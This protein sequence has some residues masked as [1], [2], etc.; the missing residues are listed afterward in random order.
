MRWPQSVLDIVEDDE[1]TAKNRVPI[2]LSPEPSRAARASCSVQECGS[3]TPFQ[4]SVI[5]PLRYRKE[6]VDRRCD[7]ANGAT[8]N[9]S[10]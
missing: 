7:R 9:H 2:F 8:D 4:G 1:I 5:Q 10:D 6:D 3:N